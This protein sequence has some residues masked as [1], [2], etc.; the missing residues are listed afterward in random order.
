MYLTHNASMV[1]LPAT[2]HLSVFMS[3]KRLVV[4][5]DTYFPSGR[6]DVDST[7]SASECALHAKEE[8]SLCILLLGFLGPCTIRKEHKVIS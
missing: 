4:N 6:L 8:A 2:T 7:S 3:M 5:T 1:R